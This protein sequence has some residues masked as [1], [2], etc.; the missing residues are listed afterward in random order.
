MLMYE[1]SREPE[2]RREVSQLQRCEARGSLDS[3]TMKLCVAEPQEQDI[4]NSRKTSTFT[5]RAVAVM[6]LENNSSADM[7]CFGGLCLGWVHF[8]VQLLRFCIR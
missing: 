6:G 5:V 2:I 8:P 1:V 4:V 3:G 7:R